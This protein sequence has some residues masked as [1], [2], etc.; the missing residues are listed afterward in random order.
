MTE[1]SHV[2]DG[3]CPVC[4]E[5]MALLAERY[6]QPVRSPQAYH[7]PAGSIAKRLA[8]LADLPHEDDPA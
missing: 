4:Q 8:E 6:S 1:H 7:D 5:V 3:D 2:I